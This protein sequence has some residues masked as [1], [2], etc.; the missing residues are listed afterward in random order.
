MKKTIVALIALCVLGCSAQ[1][2]WVYSPNSYFNTSKALGGLTAVV[3]PF[4]DGRYNENKNRAGF[5]LIPLLPG[6]G[7][8]NYHVPE[9]QSGHLNSG[10]WTNYKPTEDYAKALVQELESAKIFKEGFFDFKKG[11]S[12]ICI[13]GRILSTQYKGTLISYGLSA[14]GP[15]LW[16]VGFPAGTISNELMLEISCLDAK[17]EK[18]IFTNTYTA[19]KY[20]KI[21]WI[22][23]LPN[24]FNYPSMLQN[25]FKIFIEDLQRHSS[26]I[27]QVAAV[28][29][30][31]AALPHQEDAQPQGAGQSLEKLE[32]ELNRLEE[33]KA[34]G[35]ITAEEYATLKSRLIKQ[36]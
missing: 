18:V 6:F 5:Y 30:A 31:E 14:Y 26:L 21:S 4:E 32:H 11:D 35:L 1:K 16:F 22:Y 13:K 28:Q 19:P 8:V 27:A 34:Q 12:D 17:T 9:G 23:V 15:L 24:D 2:S 29:K 33:M 36:Y 3:L 20:S 7:W 25:V 10:L